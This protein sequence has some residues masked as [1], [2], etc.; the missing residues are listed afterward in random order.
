MCA[1]CGLRS[2]EFDRPAFGGPPMPS[3]FVSYRRS[4]APGHAG[5]LYD[6]LVERFGPES[7]VKD[8]ETMESGA[9]VVEVIQETV[10]RCDAVVAVIGPRWLA[11]EAGRGRRLDDP[12]DWVRLEIASALNRHVRVVPVLVGGATMPSA[13]E[14]PVDLRQLARR[15]AVELSETAW[16]PQVDALLDSLG[17]VLPGSRDAAG[18]VLPELPANSR[19]GKPDV[20]AKVSERKAA[21]P[22]ESRRDVGAVPERT[23][24]LSYAAKD[25]DT[26]RRVAGCFEQ[27][28]WNVW[29][30]RR[31]IAGSNYARRIQSELQAATCVVVL[32][33]N[34]SIASDWVDIEAGYARKHGKLIP[35]LIDDVESDVPLEF[36]RL[37]AVDLADWSGEASHPELQSLVEAASTLLR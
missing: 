35:A 19:E 25:R 20:R 22:P 36:S 24:F 3:I 11:A 4:D 21:D 6:R 37:H 16:R 10:A 12:M 1:L 15:H 28:G 23:V 9:D 34:A 27:A 8:L 18:P 29:W 17:E 2:H 32:W 14:L 33:S 30:D 31:L 5:R 26:A 7:V 13:E